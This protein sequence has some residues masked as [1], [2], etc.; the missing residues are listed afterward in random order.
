M[1]ATPA[2]PFALIKLAC[3]AAALQ[4]AADAAGPQVVVVV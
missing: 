2:G 4:V 1:E 3:R